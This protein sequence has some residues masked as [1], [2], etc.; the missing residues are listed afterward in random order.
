MAAPVVTSVSPNEGPAA[1]GTTVTVNGTGFTN[2]TSVRFGTK[3]APSFTV[4]TVNGVTKLTAVTPSGTGTV[5]VTVTTTQGTSNQ[6][7]P[8]TYVSPVPTLSNL[9]PNQ[10][11]SSGG[12]S[13]TLTGSKLS[14]ATG[15]LFGGVAAASFTVDS[16]TQI[17][18]V[19]PAHAAGPVNVTV[20]TPGG[21]SNALAFTYVAAPSITG[22]SPN[23]GSSSGGTSVTLTGTDF[24]GATGVLFGGVAAAS[25]TVDSS[26]QITAVTPAH[27]AGP[28]AVTVTSPSGVSNPDD[29]NAF[30][31]Y[32][33]S[34]SL[35]ALAPPSGPTAGG[36][37]VTL[38]GSSLLGATAVLFDG[39]E[40][41][42]FTVDSATQLTAVTP[43]HAPGVTQVTVTTPGGTSNPVD[44]VF[45]DAPALV[46]LAPD[47]GPAHTATVVTLTGDNL[48]TTTSVQFDA[49]PASFTVVSPTQITTVVPTDTAGSVFVTVTTPAG[50]SN[51]LT[52]TR[53]AAPA[54]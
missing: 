21:T 1:G 18:A 37:T 42:S 8:F 44:Y 19:S 3:P 33:E 45:L 22:L 17:T 5:N 52:Y 34:P 32:A 7:V 12:T 20:T 29:P 16:S 30:F 40:A 47:R 43:S 6:F 38:S 2:V 10:G 39:A 54:V 4:T 35:A 26:T 15:V 9:S 24:S 53:V 23:Q 51:G 13:V 49:V 25:F 41:A 46:S 27:V 14:G 28:A 50:T 36:T 48:A 11:S 31:F